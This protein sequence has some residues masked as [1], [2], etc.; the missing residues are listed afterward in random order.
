MY[1]NRQA[2][3]APLNL[4]PDGLPSIISTVDYCWAYHHLELHLQQAILPLILPK[5]LPLFYTCPEQENV[6]LAREMYHNISKF[7]II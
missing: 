4:L 3:T 7:K 1:E 5:T 2:L 6:I